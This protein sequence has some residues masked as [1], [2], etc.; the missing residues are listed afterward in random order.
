M[1]TLP[2]TNLRQASEEFI[3]VSIEEVN[4]SLVARF[5]K[6]AARYPERNAVESQ[7]THLTYAELDRL[8]DHLAN[9]ILA[10]TE[11]RSAPIPLI[12]EHH[13]QAITAIFGVL[14]AGM[15]Y[16]PIEPHTPTARIVSI[17]EDLQ[18]ALILANNRN[19]STTLA[20]LQATNGITVINLD[21]MLGEG[22]Q[23]EE[24]H[25]PIVN[26][27]P[28]DLAYILYTS[29]STGTPKGVM[30]SHRDT[31]HNFIALTNAMKLSANE[32]VA[33]YISLT[34][35]AARFAIYAALLNGGCLCLYDI[36]ERGIAEL[37]QW[38]E[39]EHITLLLT[40][41][42]TFRH[43][44]HFLPE[45]KRLHGVRTIVMGGE[46]VNSHDVILFKKHF[47][48]HC[49]LFNTLGTTETGVI[50]QSAI[51]HNTPIQS[52]IIPAGRVV[53]E[54][55]LLI[56]DENGKAV[57]DGEVGEIVVCSR[58]LSPGYWNHPDWTAERF[59]WNGSKVGDGWYRT[60][61]LGRILPD[62]SLEY[63]GR[64]DSQIKIRGYR[65]DLGEI[66]ATLLLHPSVRNAVVI[67]RKKEGREDTSQLV[68]YVEPKNS[69]H[70]SVKQLKRYL[71][72]TLPDYMI[73]S[74]II[75]MEALPL[76]QTG[77]IDVQQ[78]PPL[79]EELQSKS[80]EH[81]AP[82][83]AIE[84]QLVQIWESALKTQPIGVRDDY[85]A[86]GGD[87]L[88]A[89][90]IFAKIEKVF[91]K[92]LPLATLLHVSTI[93][94]L[95]KILRQEDWVPDWSSLVALRPQGD[96]PPLFFAAP[97]GGNVLSYRDLI[98]YL[99]REY[100]I[101]GLQ[102]LGLDGVQLPHRSVNEIAAH[103]INE[104]KSVQPKGPYFLLG[105]SFGGLVVYE[106]AQ[107]LHDMG[108]K[109]ALVVM[110]DTYGPNYPRRLPGTSRLM[111][112][113]YKLL[114]TVDTHLSNLKYADWR[115]RA[116]YVR[117]KSQKLW[118]R[119]KRKVEH[120]VNTLYQPL[121]SELRK[122]RSAQMRAAKNRRAKYQRESIRF[123]GRL[124]LFKASRQP[125]GVYPDEKLGWGS[126]VGDAI[127]VFEI[128][129]HHTSLIYEPRVHLVAKKL[130]SILAEM[131]AN[132]DSMKGNVHHPTLELPN[133]IKE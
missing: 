29:G 41:P 16:V 80:Q 126:V 6:I 49:V 92:K 78:L 105:S 24:I 43:M 25:A 115:G 27:Q 113:F 86:L 108:D 17:L 87:S 123:N 23:R 11:K 101:Y 36:R 38:I 12:L 3:P 48:K 58:F 72:N 103:Y 84:K 45:K 34:F 31:M 51:N 118:Q 122:V 65:V 74:Q 8:S 109:V 40:T 54:K 76:T 102:A 14:K 111:R 121:P 133:T 22:A 107:Q 35:E 32:R 2:R 129:G 68:A 57:K 95:A 39:E 56:W 116:A 59:I 47:S 52:N 124:V 30:H 10:L 61:D 88:I 125:F 90:Q 5:R 55:E 28:D 66:Q 70:I 26:I 75:L 64:K 79:E 106:M 132:P 18:P 20:A 85:F 33:L 15:A 130:T 114:Q 67:T 104:V 83:D 50:T 98:Q 131:T 91:G 1:K 21:N 96:K 46:V 53:G 94:E 128:P 9:A 110:F 100:P 112:R 4:T 44:I 42:S 81:L 117:R 77:K 13:S 71:A 7:G 19:L 60:G 93:E 69:S 97:V 63:L 62:G 120:K 82:R 89:A 119:L 99:P 127:E 73:P 37:S